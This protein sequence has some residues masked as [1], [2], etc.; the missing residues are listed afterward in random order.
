MSITEQNQRASSLLRLPA[1]LRLQIYNLV[2][3]RRV[4]HV[5]MKWSGICIPA[6]FQY[7]CL[8][9]TDPLL[10]SSE[11]KTLAH[12]VP[13]GPDLRRLSETC[14]QI[15]GETAHLPF[16]THIWSFET[17]FTLDQWVSMKSQVPLAHK[18]TIRTVA[19]PP[20]GPYRSS[21]RILLSLHEVLLVGT[22]H[23]RPADANPNV[24][25]QAST[26]AILILKKDKLGGTYGA[27]RSSR[28]IFGRGAFGMPRP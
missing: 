16:E 14:R 23:D 6:G 24:N 3:P 11:K 25:Q 22:A 17:A 7:T 5:R 19:V 27:H 13:F 18:N 10:A 15:H 1:E 21:E 26:K 20:P 2:I 12:A 9:N 8:E 4:I 28:T